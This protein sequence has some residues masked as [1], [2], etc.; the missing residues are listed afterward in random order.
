MDTG[1][2]AP[3]APANIHPFLP[4]GLL[5]LPV[6]GLYWAGHRSFGYRVPHWLAMACRS[7]P[8]SLWSFK[9][10][11]CL[12]VPAQWEQPSGEGWARNGLVHGEF[13]KGQG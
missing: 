6:L 12:T 5:G 2:P 1:H 7:G 4:T 13:Q 11:H 9:L 8:S 3:Q 10:W